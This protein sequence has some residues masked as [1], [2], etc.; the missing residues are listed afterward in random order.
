MVFFHDFPHAVAMDSL[1]CLGGG[2]G[3]EERGVLYQCQDIYMY[4]Q[5]R[6][7]LSNGLFHDFPHAVA[8]D[9]LTCLG[10]GGG[11]ERRGEF[12]INAKIFTCMSN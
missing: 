4:V 9:S 8:M 10:G 6:Q 12:Y 5:L 3:G 1:T 11:G 2:G 7:C